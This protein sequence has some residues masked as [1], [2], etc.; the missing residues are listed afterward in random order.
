[1]RQ[2]ATLEQDFLLNTETIFSCL[3]YCFP[4]LLSIFRQKDI[5]LHILFSSSS[6]VRPP[7]VGDAASLC[8]LSSGDVLL[9]FSLQLKTGSDNFGFHTVPQ[10]TSGRYRPQ[11]VLLVNR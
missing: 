5:S 1:M 11:G 7:S 3:S 10:S 6:D 9:L 4:N 2:L 8:W